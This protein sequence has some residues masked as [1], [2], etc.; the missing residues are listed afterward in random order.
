M[1]MD[2]F[3]DANG[4]P[5]AMDYNGQK[6]YYILNLQGDVIC[7]V[8][9]NGDSWATYT[10]DEWGNPKWISDNEYARN[11]PLRYRG[12]VYDSETGFYYCQSR[13]YDPA[14]GRFIN[15]DSFASTG[16]CIIGN[17]MFAYCLNNS[18]NSCDP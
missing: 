17:N 15:A 2:F 18:V 6:L 13:Y 7:M 3:Y 9:P 12:Y 14:I 11:N 16:Q 10:Y 5:Y 1:V 4:N 8:S